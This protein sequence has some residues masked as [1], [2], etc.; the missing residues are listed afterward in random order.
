MVLPREH[1]AKVGMRIGDIVL[2][3]RHRCIGI[4]VR[5]SLGTTQFVTPFLEEA[6]HRSQHNVTFKFLW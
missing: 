6:D 5:D 2:E 1:N 4:V 3:G